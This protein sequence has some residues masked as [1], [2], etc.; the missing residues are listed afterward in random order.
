METDLFGNPSPAPMP[1]NK[2]GGYA[3]KPGTGPEGENCKSCTHVISWTWHD[4][5]YYKCELVKPTHGPGTDIRLKSP[6]CW[7]WNPGTD[8]I[9][10]RRENGKADEDTA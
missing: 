5:R 7:A 3:H 9:E 6:A 10:T 4:R 8:Y 2:V 1:K